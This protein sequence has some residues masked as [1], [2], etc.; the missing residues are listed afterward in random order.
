M[1]CRDFIAGA[2]VA[3]WPLAVRAQ[4]PQRARRIGVL[5]NLAAD[6]REGQERLAL[7]L[8]TLQD[9]GWLDGRNVK[10]ET[11]LARKQC[12]SISQMCSGIGRARAGRHSGGDDASSGAI[13]ASDSDRADH[14]CWCHRSSRLG[15]G[16]E[17][18][19]LAS[20]S[21]EITRSETLPELARLNFQE[22]RNLIIDERTAQGCERA[23][24][25]P[26]RV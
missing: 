4:Q 16:G 11:P 24:G 9:Q 7:F 19:A 20:T 8:R 22:G 2:A 14:L 13:K 10:I 6:D 17:Q 25:D 21:L 18:L 26:L 3:A 23:R 12:R 15:L 5:T 1:K